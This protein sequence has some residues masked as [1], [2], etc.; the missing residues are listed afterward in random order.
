[1]RKV[2][3]LFVL[4]LFSVASVYAFSG[5]VGAK[6]SYNRYYD[7]KFTTVTSQGVSVDVVGS[8]TFGKRG[9]FGFEYSASKEF[10]YGENASTNP[11]YFGISSLFE[12]SAS[13]VLSMDLTAGAKYGIIPFGEIMT[14]T[15]GV[16]TGFD[17]NFTVVPHFTIS[18]GVDYLIP[19][20]MFYGDT[21]KFTAI[22]SHMVSYGLMFSYS[23]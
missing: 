16:V 17:M 21:A 6:V 23:Y 12:F 19:V 11:W 22:D 18:L 5:R 3:L 13:D 15:L 4:V 9:I 14:S 7:S 8:N 1:M 20:M 2:F 10:T